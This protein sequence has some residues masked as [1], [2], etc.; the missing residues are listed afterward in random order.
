[1]G[2]TLQFLYGDVDVRGPGG[3]SCRGIETV[4]HVTPNAERSNKKLN[5]GV[6]PTNRG[7]WHTGKVGSS[8]SRANFHSRVEVND[9]LRTAAPFSS[10]RCRVFSLP[11]STLDDD[12]G[13]GGSTIGSSAT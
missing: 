9:A 10:T 2:G 6:D 8:V 7:A 4:T 11:F 3:C 5:R 13:C 12:V 1:M